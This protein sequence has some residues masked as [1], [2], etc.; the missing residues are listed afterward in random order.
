MYGAGA[1]HRV[2]NIGVSLGV[3]RDESEIASG[4]SGALLSIRE[5]QP[6]FNVLLFR[7]AMVLTAHAVAM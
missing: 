6:Q 4:G 2:G 7:N 3:G 1:K 5:M